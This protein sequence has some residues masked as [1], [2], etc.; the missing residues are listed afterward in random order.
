M[1][2][3][4]ATS[5]NCGFNCH[6]AKLHNNLW[7]VVH[8]YVP[9]SQSCITWYW[10]KDGDVPLPCKLVVQNCSPILRSHSL[11]D[12]PVVGIVVVTKVV[13]GNDD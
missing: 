9:L 3:F 12:D 10:S 11:I 4:W 5:L 6:R 1:G 13:I 7:Q 8:T 2:Q